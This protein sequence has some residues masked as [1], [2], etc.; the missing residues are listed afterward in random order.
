MLGVS[1][2]SKCKNSRAKLLCKL[3]PP[4]AQTGMIMKCLSLLAG[5]FVFLLSSCAAL[6]P[7][8][9]HNTPKPLPTSLN[10][11]VAAGNFERFQAG[12]WEEG[13]TIC[14][15][16]RLISPN[17]GTKWAPI[18]GVIIT[19]EDKKYFGAIQLIYDSKITKKVSMVY[20]D[21]GELKSVL[22]ENIGLGERVMYQLSFP[23]TGGFDVLIGAKTFHFETHAEI[24]AM[25]IIA[26]SSQSI[27]EFDTE[28]CSF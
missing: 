14:A 5:T 13:Q 18:A 8:P 24:K 19:S 3:S 26:S 11:N 21:T 10:F 7:S 23:T 2:R 28:S 22:Q 9:P 20:M 25:Y 17:L 12:T 4:C 6:K 16:A 1:R 27:V 15:A